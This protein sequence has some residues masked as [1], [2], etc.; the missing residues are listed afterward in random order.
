[1]N[2]PLFEN[3]QYPDPEDSRF[4]FR[5]IYFHR[6]GF[7]VLIGILVI[8]ELLGVWQW[9]VL[10]ELSWRSIFGIL[11]PPVVLVIL[12]FQYKRGLKIQIARED[13]LSS[14]GAEDKPAAYRFY[15]DFFTYESNSSSHR[16]SY[17]NLKKTI[18][19]DEH[20]IIVT[21]S[22]IYYELNRNCF[23]K[24]DPQGLLRFLASKGIQ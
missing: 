16:V 22:K 12:F 2:E 8:L 10:R 23:T 19:H 9:L 4:L 1:M 6:P 7:W 3:V 17:A 13:E 20:L 21:N 24:G 5:Y 14:A 11:Y 15:D 18:V